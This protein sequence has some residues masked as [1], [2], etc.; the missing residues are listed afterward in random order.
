LLFRFIYFKGRKKKDFF[1]FLVL[2]DF[3]GFMGFFVTVLVGCV[4]FLIAVILVGLI[5]RCYLH[6]GYLLD[7]PILQ[8]RNLT[9]NY[10]IVTGANRGIGFATAKYLVMHG[11]RVILACRDKQSGLEAQHHINRLQ[12]KRHHTK[13]CSV[14]RQF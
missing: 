3:F 7:P 2:F 13:N 1:S 12:T 11:A 6:E 5:I 9:G 8:H 10:V 4:V 14:E